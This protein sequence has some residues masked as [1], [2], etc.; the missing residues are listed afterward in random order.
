MVDK[1]VR[2]RFMGYIYKDVEGIVDLRYKVIY[3]GSRMKIVHRE[4]CNFRKY[5]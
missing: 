1:V 3:T 4:F 2:I 5:K